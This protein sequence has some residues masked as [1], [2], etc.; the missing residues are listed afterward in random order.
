MVSISLTD[1]PFLKRLAY[2]T[3]QDLSAEVLMD[4]LS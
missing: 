2:L 1:H 4:L 3:L